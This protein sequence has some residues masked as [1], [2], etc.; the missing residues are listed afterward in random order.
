MVI[1]WHYRASVVSKTMEKITVE[2][3]TEQ[4][5]RKA[6]LDN[7]GTLANYDRTHYIDQA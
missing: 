2:Y 4:L 3:S 5:K 7:G 6:H 1:L